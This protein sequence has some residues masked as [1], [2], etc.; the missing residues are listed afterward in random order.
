[1]VWYYKYLPYFILERMLHAQDLDE[2]ETLILKG[3]ESKEYKICLIEIQPGLW[4]GTNQKEIIEGKKKQL[5]KQLNEVNKDLEG[6]EAW[7]SN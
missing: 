6:L 1:M 5:E 2:S 7:Y 3:Y 4:L